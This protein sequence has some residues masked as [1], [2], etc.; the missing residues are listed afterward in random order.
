MTNPISVIPAQ[1]TEQ[2][3]ITP[4]TL[5]RWCEAHKVHLSSGAN[6]GPGMSR[7]FTGR[8]LEVL[9]QVR[10]LSAQ[11]LNPEQINE[12]LHLLTFPEL[13]LN[14]ELVASSTPVAPVYDA[15]ITSV[16]NAQ[17]NTLQPV[18]VS[19]SAQIFKRL[20]ALEQNTR[21]RLSYVAIGVML[22]LGL[23]LVFELAALLAAR[24][25]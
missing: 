19:D 23:A 6:P 14:T 25:H 13:E 15:L 1:I 3:A 16:T 17:I 20:D 21:D 18:D 2:L 22:G 12:Q 8:D 5:R 24:V 4:I 11:G 7:L 10:A 9:K